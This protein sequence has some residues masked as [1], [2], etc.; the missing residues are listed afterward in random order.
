MTESE[1]DARAIILLI[2]EDDD[3][4]L[5]FKEMLKNKGYK[6]KLTINEDDALEKAGNGI[7][8]V[9]VVLVDLVRKPTKEILKAGERI[10]EKGRLNVPVIAI[11]EE[12]KDELQGTSVQ[13]GENEYVVYLKDLVELFDLLSKLTTAKPS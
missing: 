11:A 7:G 10:R 1:K 12:Y 6:V 5:I 3:T 8:K 9:D 13:I 4:R 2:E